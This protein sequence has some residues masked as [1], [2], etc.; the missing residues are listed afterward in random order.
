MKTLAESL[1]AAVRRRL[2]GLTSP[3]R[4]QAYLDSFPYSTDKFYRC[5][6]RVMLDRR[7]HCFDGA[8]LAAACLRALGFPPLILDMHAQRDDDHLVAP[9][10]VAGCWGAVAKS[11]FVGLRY[12]EPVYRSLR[13]LVMSYFEAFFN[14]DSERTLRTYTRPI[15]LAAFDHLDWMVEDGPLEVIA[16]RSDH[17]PRI[18]LLTP[19]Q[20]RRL[21]RLDSRSYQ[22]GMLGTDLAGVYRPRPRRR[23]TARV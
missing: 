22:A 20:I 15:H 12:R 13:E 5:P 10:R 23:P 2:A 9:F 8:L 16:E 18:P 6:R 3:V 1:P 4:I 7:A 14:L 21:T 17:V 11:N 19:G